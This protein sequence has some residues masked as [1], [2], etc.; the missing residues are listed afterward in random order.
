MSV[1]SIQNTAWDN[2]NW[3]NATALGVLPLLEY[4]ALAFYSKAGRMMTYAS[5]SQ[6]EDAA[7]YV[8][9]ARW[10]QA[11]ARTDPELLPENQSTE[12][13]RKLVQ[14]A[15][16][17]LEQLVHLATAGGVAPSAP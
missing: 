17:W 8:E 15:W 3:G 4:K 1:D 12:T 2:S 10:L 6:G 14:D 16:K 5:S 13:G 9:D 7:A 11:A